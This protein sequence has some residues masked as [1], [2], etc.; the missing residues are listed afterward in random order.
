M[1]YI[2][3]DGKVFNTEYEC[4]E[5]ERKIVQERV[6]KEKLEMKRQ[7]R[8]SSINKKYEDLKKEISEYNSDYGVSVMPY[9][10]LI[11][12]FYN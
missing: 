9:K 5:Y 1:R 12:L 4:C 6:E 8:L 11:K 7:K 2:S 3:D 10:E